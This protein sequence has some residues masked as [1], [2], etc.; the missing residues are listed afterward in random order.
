VHF[1]LAPV[2]IAA[3]RVSYGWR[4][5]IPDDCRNLLCSISCR[6]MILGAAEPPVGAE[7]LSLGRSWRSHIHCRD[8]VFQGRR[9]FP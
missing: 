8:V 2:T 4:S 6:P 5:I 9:I 1:A 7:D 3:V